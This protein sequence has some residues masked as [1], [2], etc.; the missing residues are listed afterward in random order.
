MPDTATKISLDAHLNAVAELKLPASAIA[1]LNAARADAKAAFLANADF[2]ATSLGV[3][4]ENDAPVW[5]AGFA[6][7]DFYTAL[8]GQTN[9]M[10]VPVASTNAFALIGA[11]DGFLALRPLGKNCHKFVWQ[12]LKDAGLA[13]YF[14]ASVMTT[15]LGDTAFATVK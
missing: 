9:G 11:L 13:P 1:Q 2:R 6:D 4:T 5:D 10:F 12:M 14:N 15:Q 7:K 3:S 8:F